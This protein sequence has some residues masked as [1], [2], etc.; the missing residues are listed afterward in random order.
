MSERALKSKLL[1]PAADW[2]AFA[3][4]ESVIH[5]KVRLG[6]VSVL[7]THAELS[8]TELREGLQL[9]DGNLA[10]HLRALEAAGVIRARKAAGAG[11][12]ATEF[13]LTAAGRSAFTRYLDSLEQIVKRHR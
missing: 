6:I 13:A 5:S 4:L 3:R 2:Q 12:P 10:A 1:M 8:F 7:A 9:T 11:K